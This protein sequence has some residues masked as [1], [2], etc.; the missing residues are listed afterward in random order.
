MGLHATPI[1]SSAV[2]YFTPPEILQNFIWDFANLL[3]FKHVI[4]HHA[5]LYLQIWYKDGFQSC[6]LANGI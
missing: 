4:Y 6:M 2:R 3:T 1:S 5:N